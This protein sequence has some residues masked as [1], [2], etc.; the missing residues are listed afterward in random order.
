MRTDTGGR[1]R[2]ARSLLA[3][4]KLCMPMLAG[5]LERTLV[6]PEC[7]QDLSNL[8]SQYPD[9]VPGRYCLIVRRH[10]DP[11]SAEWLG[12][13]ANPVTWDVGQY[14]GFR[15]PAPV[16]GWQCGYYDLGPPVGSSA[17]QWHCDRVGFLLNTYQ[18]THTVPLDGGGPDV[19]YERWLGEPLPRLWQRPS[20]RLSIEVD[21]LLWVY[22]LQHDPQTG[23]STGQA[24]LLCYARHV[25]SGRIFAH[26]LALFD[27]RAPGEGNGDEFIG[28]DTVYDF[29]SSPAA[30]LT[31]SGQAPR[32]LRR[33]AGSASFANQQGWTAARRFRAE[34]GQ[35]ELAQ[36]LQDLERQGL[37]AAR[38]EDYG[39]CGVGL[40][41][42]AFP[43]SANDF[44]VSLGGRISALRV[45][46]SNDLLLQADGFE[47]AGRRAPGSGV[48]IGD[49]L[50]LQS[51]DA[52]LEHQLALLQP[53]ELELVD[54]R[55]LG[56]PRNG[57]IEV[58]VLDLHFGKAT[59]D[60]GRVE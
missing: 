15:P 39:L 51:G 9:E 10:G 4:L 52:V 36:V 38:P 60:G 24:S 29:A 34:I 56:K 59:S 12:Q 42:E 30:D 28:H 25:P 35:A 21:L 40:L 8:H 58:A 23:R 22:A 5:A 43:G 53:L 32:Y 47:A 1:A 44:N 11:G 13:I 26:V 49:Q 57:S 7:A 46:F 55:Q 3:A 14:T 16:S 31:A 27:T 17:V 41:V 20:D 6:A 45:A 48:E 37:P 19:A 33:G 54:G 18:F 2:S 50:A